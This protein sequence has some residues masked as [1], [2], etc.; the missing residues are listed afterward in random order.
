MVNAGGPGNTDGNRVGIST[1]CSALWGARIGNEDGT[2]ILVIT[3]QHGNEVQSTEAVLGVIK[4]LAK[5]SGR[6]TRELLETLNVLF[7]VRANSDSGEPSPDCFIGTPLGAPIQ[8]D[9]AL[10]R[11]NLDPSAG[12]GYLG[13]TEPGFAGTVGS[14]YNLNRYHFSDLRRPYAPSKRRPWWR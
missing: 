7:V 1:Q 13:L 4:Q 10:N 2:R 6:Q 5:S 8:K 14:G 11:F 12:G 3:Q 9:C